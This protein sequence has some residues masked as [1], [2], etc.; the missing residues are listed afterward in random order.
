MASFGKNKCMHMLNMI[1]YVFYLEGGQLNK[2]PVTDQG[3]EWTH[4][5]VRC[6][7][8]KLQR[9]CISMPNLRGTDKK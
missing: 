2:F 1:K 9:P 3:F 5:V 8:C 4:G 6:Q 7:Y